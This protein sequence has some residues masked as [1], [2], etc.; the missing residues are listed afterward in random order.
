MWPRP[1]P[2]GDHGVGRKFQ[3]TAYLSRRLEVG[4]LLLNDKEA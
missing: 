2:Q 4:G 1:G 3:G